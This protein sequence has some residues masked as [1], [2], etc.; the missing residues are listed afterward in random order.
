MRF[1][2]L[3]D[4]QVGDGDPSLDPV[5]LGFQLKLLLLA[6][7]LDPAGSGPIEDLVARPLGEVS[8]PPREARRRCGW[9]SPP[10]PT[11]AAFACARCTPD[12]PGRAVTQPDSLRPAM[13]HTF[14]GMLS[15]LQAYWEAQGCMIMQPYH[16]EVG[17]G[18]F[19]PATFLRVLGPRPWRIAYVEPSI[20]PDDGRYGENPFRLQQF[21]STR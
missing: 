1:L 2:E 7:Y 9:S 15:A 20:R 12:G 6:G 11:T 5:G 13:A 21:S 3:L 18:T 19:N 14:Q 4:E 16:T 10:T 17:A 8:S